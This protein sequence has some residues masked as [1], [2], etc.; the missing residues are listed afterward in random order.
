MK[1]LQKFVFENKNILKMLSTDES[2]KE[3]KKNDSSVDGSLT[4]A[5]SHDGCIEFM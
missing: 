1:F 5:I 3:V 4:L 2:K